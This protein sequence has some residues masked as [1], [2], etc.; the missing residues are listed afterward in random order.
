MEWAAYKKL[1][2]VIRYGCPFQSR[3]IREGAIAGITLARGE[4]VAAKAVI[5]ACGG[6]ENKPNLRSEWLGAEWSSAK[7]RGTPHNTSD[8]LF[9]ERICRFKYSTWRLEELSQ[10]QLLSRCDVE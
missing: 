1:G 5:L 7:V 10:G 9:C 2:E 4:E 3:Q 6:F 8:R